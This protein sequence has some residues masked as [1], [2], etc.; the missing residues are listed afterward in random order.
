VLLAGDFNVWDANRV[1]F[2]ALVTVVS[3]GPSFHVAR[4]TNML[5]RFVLS[6]WLRAVSS[7]DR[8]SALSRRLQITFLWS[9]ISPLRSRP[10]DDLSTNSAL[11]G[12]IGFT[13][14][15]LRR[16][17]LSPPARLAW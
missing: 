14:R 5:D 4:S 8:Q 9:L 16:D 15:I 7:Y 12:V 10:N 3:P 2:A 11:P 13:I 1:T 17:D 6:S